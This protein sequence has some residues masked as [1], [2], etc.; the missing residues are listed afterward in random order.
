[1]TTFFS[2]EAVSVE[3]PDPYNIQAKFV[4]NY[5]LPNESV[6][7]TSDKLKPARLVNI[8]FP[9]VKSGDT[10]WASDQLKLLIRFYGKEDRLLSFAQP[11]YEVST[12]GMTQVS[13]EDTDL[14]PRL[15]DLVMKQIEK[16]YPGVD[17]DTASL[18][19]TD[20]TK[21]LNDST[22]NRVDG[23]ILL[24]LVSD[25]SS[26]STAFFDRNDLEIKNNLFLDASS[27]KFDIQ[28]SDKFIGDAYLQMSRNPISPVADGAV[29]E[30]EK[31]LEIQD[32]FRRETGAEIRESDYDPDFIHVGSPTILKNYEQPKVGTCGYIVDKFIVG[33]SGERRHLQSFFIKDNSMID[34]KVLYGQTYTYEARTLC[35]FGMSVRGKRIAGI[36]P[37]L[38]EKFFRVLFLI[39]SRASRQ[40]KVKCIENIPPPPPNFVTY[41]YDYDNDRLCIKWKFPHTSQGDIKKFQIF[42]RT[43]ILVPFELIAQYDFSDSL[44]PPDDIEDVDPSINY[45]MQYGRTLFYDETFS[46]SGDAIYAIV[47]VD[48]HNMTSNYSEQSRVTFDRSRNA[49]TISEISKLGAPK[50]YPNFFISTT[51]AQNIETVRYTEDV[52]KDSGHLRMKVYFDPETLEITGNRFLTRSSSSKNTSNPS[53]GTYKFQ[54]LNIDRQKMSIVDIGI[55]DNRKPN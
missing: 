37:K 33:E 39:K 6:V 31:I 8:Q 14:G 40:A 32:K 50:Q 46:R 28:F 24:D 10:R 22:S 18:S 21:I 3:V 29:F 13:I 25:L 43:S 26:D 52:I 2:K 45:R 47:A 36:D 12:P 54:V 30:S 20:L 17:L 27:V 4:Y 35:L 7:D 34:T 16:F 55:N 49:I 23:N 53:V 42:K 15:Q 5:Y 11:E 41:R 1:M 51:S 9:A 38:G 19:Q 48:A 44:I